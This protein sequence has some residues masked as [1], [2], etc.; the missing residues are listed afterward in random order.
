MVGD[1]YLNLEGIEIPHDTNETM[2]QDLSGI[3]KV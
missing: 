2:R 1:M 3:P